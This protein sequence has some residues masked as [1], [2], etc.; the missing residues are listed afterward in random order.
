MSSVPNAI[1]YR[2]SWQQYWQWSIFA[3]HR[4]WL[5]PLPER[6]RALKRTR[7]IGDFGEGGAAANFA[8]KRSLVIR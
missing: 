8:K 7:N 2:R 1:W 4:H 3:M 5:K 6:K